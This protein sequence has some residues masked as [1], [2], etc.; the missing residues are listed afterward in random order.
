MNTYRIPGLETTNKGTLI[1]VY[2]VRRNNSGDL[3][4]NIDIGM[5]R[6]TDKGLTWEPMKIIMD[7]DNLGWFA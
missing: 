1:A 4:D 3:Q 2:D 5:S 7:M 6:S